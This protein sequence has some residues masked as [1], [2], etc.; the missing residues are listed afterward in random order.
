MKKVMIFS[1]LTLVFLILLLIIGYF[2][3]KPDYC[4][5]YFSVQHLR[6]YNSPEITF[7]HYIDAISAGDPNYYQE[8]LG[9][10]ISQKE[11]EYL[12]KNPY[13]GKAPEIKKIIIKKD[14][15]YIITDN[16]WGVNLEKVRGR[17]VFS[18]EDISFIYREFLR[19]LGF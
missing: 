17:W 5:K 19:V 1:L 2:A 8:V 15:V 16:N 7:K 10:K 12:I 14:Y 11:I 3:T 13:R 18:P 9:R 4:P 6:K